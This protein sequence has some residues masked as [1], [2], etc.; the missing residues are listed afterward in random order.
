MLPGR[1]SRTLS[2]MST[3]A[4]DLPWL[5]LYHPAP[6]LIYGVVRTIAAGLFFAIILLAGYLISEEFLI[7]EVAVALIAGMT[8]SVFLWGSFAVWRH[9]IQPLLHGRGTMLRAVTRLPFWFMAGGM[10]YTFGMLIVASARLLPVP[11]RPVAALFVAGGKWFAGIQLIW[12]A[13]NYFAQRRK[14][15]Q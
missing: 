12:E 11:D 6:R 5:I 13:V 4:R 1:T 2:G 8:V 9:A 3:G 15:N 14:H 10:G 7:A